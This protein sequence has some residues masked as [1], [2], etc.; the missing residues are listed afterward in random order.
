[1]R[2]RLAFLMI[3]SILVA[4]SGRSVEEQRRSFGNDEFTPAAWAAADQLARVRMLA[5]FLRKHPAEELNTQQ[6]K[7]LLG[8]PTGYADY[9]ENPAY[10]RGPSDVDS[11]YD[12]GHLL[13][14]VSDKQTGRIQQLRLVPCVDR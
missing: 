12:R 13:I 1:M 7:E 3:M 4:Y 8:K 9:D 14:F 5:S 2:A 11:E 10:F 6:V